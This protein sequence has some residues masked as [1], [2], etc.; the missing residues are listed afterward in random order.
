M[1]NTRMWNDS[2]ISNL[3]PISKLL[4]VYFLTNEHG[5]ICGIYELPLK[6]AAMETGIDETMFRRLFRRMKPKVFYRKG[7]VIVVNFPKYQ[8]L[9]L[10]KVKQ[11]FNDAITAIPKDILEYAFENGYRVD[12]Q[13]ISNKL[14]T[15]NPDSD[16]DPDSKREYTA[17]AVK[18]HFSIGHEIK[19]LEDSNRRELN[20]IAFYLERRK[21]SVSSAEQLQ[22]FI[23]RHLRDAMSA[24]A[25]SDSDLARA[26]SKAQSLTPD[27]TIGTLVK[28]LTK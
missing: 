15:G 16:L 2:F 28:V 23:K 25:F 6:I 3:D 1:V 18:D 7:W 9:N 12:Y 19:K 8:S 27:W 24:R 22:V 20:V 5:N 10:P 17:D 13:S 26:V 4:F 21:A 11:G 14:Q